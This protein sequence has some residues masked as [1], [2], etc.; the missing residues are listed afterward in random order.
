MFILIRYL[1]FVVRIICPVVIKNCQVTRITIA[2]IFFLI[3]IVTKLECRT[4]HI[5][6]VAVY[7]DVEN[8]R[9]S[10]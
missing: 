1:H 5:D 3:K 2:L 9:E 6:C 10:T 8:G 7:P 4:G